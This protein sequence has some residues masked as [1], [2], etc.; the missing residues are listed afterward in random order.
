MKHDF[1]GHLIIES[2]FDTAF[3]KFKKLDNWIFLGRGGK[4]PPL[5]H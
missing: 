3:G 2:E 1:H 5:W 4:V